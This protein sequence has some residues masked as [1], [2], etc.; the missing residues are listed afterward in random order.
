MYVR[1]IYHKPTFTGVYLNWTSL[2]SRKYKISLIY[3][4]CDRIWRFCRE[5]NERDLELKK[6]KQTLIKNEY[7][8]HIINKEIEKFIKNRTDK[9]QQQEQQF[10]EQQQATVEKQN[11]YIVL[12]YSNNKVDA[13]ASKLT[14]PN[15][16]HLVH[17]S[18]SLKLLVLISVLEF[19][20]LIPRYSQL[21]KT[22][23]VSI[24][25]EFTVLILLYFFLFAI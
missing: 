10:A 12:P 2:T 24:L 9:E 15:M 6:L 13:F 23:T 1:I 11:K 18:S 4:L 19:L 8:E 17:I 14:K 21:F 7:P 22:Q 16:H 3:C 20:L 5:P 25:Y